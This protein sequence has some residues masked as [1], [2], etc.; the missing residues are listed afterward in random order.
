MVV[1]R[2]LLFAIVLVACTIHAKKRA[3]VYVVPPYSKMEDG[4]VASF[5]DEGFDEVSMDDMRSFDTEEYPFRYELK[6]RRHIKKA[7]LIA[8]SLIYLNGTKRFLEEHRDFRIKAGKKTVFVESKH[9]GFFHLSILSKFK[10]R[11]KRAVATSNMI[12]NAGMTGGC[13]NVCD[14]KKKTC[15]KDPCKNLPTTNIQ[16]P[17]NNDCSIISHDASIY[18]ISG[19]PHVQPQ[20]NA[21]VV[22]TCDA[23]I[24]AVMAK[25]NKNGGK[26]DVYLDA[27]GNHGLF[28][29]GEYGG[30]HEIVSKGS[31][32]YNK[33][34]M[35][36][37]NKIKTLTLFTCSTAGGTS[38]PIFLQC[39]ANC[40][41]AK[42]KAFKKPVSI[43]AAWNT[44]NVSSIVWSTP[45]NYSTPC[46]ATPSPSPTTVTPSSNTPTPTPTPTPTTEPPTTVSTVTETS[47]VSTET[48]PTVQTETEGPTLYTDYE[49][50][51]PGLGPE[52]DFYT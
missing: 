13:E 10:L 21:T 24:A 51:E 37:K 15:K 28:A 38:G 42:V 32:C 17:P 29:I 12:L 7:Y 50:G 6:T 43:Q 25:F 14:P 3:K 41:N 52:T 45:R 44:T 48:E 1:I 47:T 40:L 11:G 33:I 46:E 8:P 19:K 39:L 31:A 23:F 30:S 2:A 34:C 4:I 16:C 18:N 20:G 22:K 27:H 26:V 35:Q 36:L 49:I 9:V 5:K